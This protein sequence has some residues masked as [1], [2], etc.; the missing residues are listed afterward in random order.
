MELTSPNIWTG[1]PNPARISESF[2][3]LD[4][5]DSIDWSISIIAAHSAFHDEV[6]NMITPFPEKKRRMTR[7][8]LKK[9]YSDKQRGLLGFF[10]L[11]KK[12]STGTLCV[13]GVGLCTLGPVGP[14]L[15]DGHSEEK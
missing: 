11:V 9:K 3:L 4:A 5:L 12:V 15:T 8:G 10:K 6:N 7:Y 14:K 1:S 13:C 2:L